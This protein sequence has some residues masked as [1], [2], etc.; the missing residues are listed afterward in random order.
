[1]PFHREPCGHLIPHGAGEASGSPP[2]SFQQ[3]VVYE[4]LQRRDKKKIQALCAIM[5]KYLTGIWACLKLNVSFDSSALFS[6]VHLNGG[7]QLKNL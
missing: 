5:R 7:K 3:V 4:T 6:K 2:T 1:L